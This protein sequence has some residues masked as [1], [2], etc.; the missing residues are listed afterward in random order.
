MILK[1]DRR[2][3]S[4]CVFAT[5]APRMFLHRSVCLASL[6]QSFSPMALCPSGAGACE[7]MVFYPFFRTNRNFISNYP[8]TRITSQTMKLINIVGCEQ[9][10]KLAGR[11]IANCQF[12]V[13]SATRTLDTKRV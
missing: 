4:V 8:N 12:A 1:T 11:C 13:D 2:K 3:R 10:F 9:V 6:H 5:L 7:K